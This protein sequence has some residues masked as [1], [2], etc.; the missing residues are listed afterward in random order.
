MSSPISAQEPDSLAVIHVGKFKSSDST[1]ESIYGNGLVFGGEVRAAGPRLA[2]GQLMF[3]A[4]GSSRRR[5]GQ[6]SFTGEPTK[7]RVNAIEAGLLHRLGRGRVSPYLG[8]CLGYYMFSET[9]EPI[10]KAAQ[11]KIGYCGVAGASIAATRRI[12]IDVR[13]KYSVSS[14]QPAD[15]PIKIGGLTVGGGVGVRF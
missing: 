10:G 3:W 9:N 8:G 7:V 2:A 13:V 1:F 11:G 14:M 15:F 12:A 5:S 6:L 4:E